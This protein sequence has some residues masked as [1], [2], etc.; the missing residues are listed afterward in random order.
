MIA[1]ITSA[2]YNFIVNGYEIDDDNKIEQLTRYVN[3]ICY[4]STVS[5]QPM[6]TY[7]NLIAV[8]GTVE[9][10]HDYGA[11]YYFFREIGE[12]NDES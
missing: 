1:T 2:L 10:F 11:D 6:P 12:D 7:F 5:Q 9:I 3:E 4:Q 8:V